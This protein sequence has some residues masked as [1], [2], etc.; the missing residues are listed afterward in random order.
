MKK[1]PKIGP[2][3]K[4]FEKRQRQSEIFFAFTETFKNE[5]WK[6]SQLAKKNANFLEDFFEKNSTQ[7]HIL[8]LRKDLG[9]PDD[10]LELNSIEMQ[11]ILNSSFFIPGIVR[12]NY[13]S[14]QKT[15]ISG[16]RKL[17]EKIMIMNFDAMS[18]ILRL[19]LFYNAYDYTF[20]RY[21]ISGWNLCKLVDLNDE[22]EDYQPGNEKTNQSFLDHFKNEMGYYPINIRIS[23]YSGQTEITNF[24]KTYWGK[25]KQQQD[26]YTKGK[27]PYIS[28]KTRR[29]IFK[30]RDRLIYENRHLPEIEIRDLVIKKYYSKSPDQ[31]EIGGIISREKRKRAD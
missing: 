2:I 5:K 6:I 18:I 15:I 25:I 23:P 12:A 20:T 29:A 26:K 1:K 27:N 28:Y 11:R 10:G 14:A 21:L 30:D 4:P 16:L 22:W 31:G 8:K 3:V 19:F 7:K 24:I 9:I 13:P 17:E